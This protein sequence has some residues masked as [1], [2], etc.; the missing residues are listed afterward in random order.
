VRRRGRP[1]DHAVVRPEPEPRVP[2]VD[3]ATLDDRARLIVELRQAGWTYEAIGR[4]VG[5][6]RQRVAQ[7]ALP[8]TR[9]GPRDP[10]LA[11]SQQR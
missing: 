8:W 10:R 11:R 5:L 1:T 3:F 4:V 7:I 9:S 6:S 2:F